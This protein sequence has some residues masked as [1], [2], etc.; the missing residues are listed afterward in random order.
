RYR[1]LG[2]RARLPVLPLYRRPALP[3]RRFPMTTRSW[4]RRLLDRKPRTKCKAP[5]RCRPALEALEDRTVPTTFQLVNVVR[6]NSDLINAIIAAN[7]GS[8]QPIIELQSFTGFNFTSAYQS[9]SDALPQITAN[10][11]IAGTSGYVNTIQR[12]TATGT[13]AFR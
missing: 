6:T 13:P 2:L 9:P 3:G 10:I 11:T 1:A 8:G 4:I 7:N 5:A 12:S